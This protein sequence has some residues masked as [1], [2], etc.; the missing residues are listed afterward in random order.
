MKTTGK[1]RLVSGASKLS[2]LAP[3]AHLHSGGARDLTALALGGNTKEDMAQGVD[4]A[5]TGTVAV[6][7]VQSASA[8]ASGRGDEGV[9]EQTYCAEDSPVTGP[10]QERVL[11]RQ[12]DE[13]A[14]AQEPGLRQRRT[15]ARTPLRALTARTGT[16]QRRY[17]TAEVW[18]AAC[19]SMLEEYAV[20][21]LIRVPLAGE[22]QTRTVNVQRGRPSNHPPPPPQRG[23]E[24][25]RDKV[26]KIRIDSQAL[27]ARIARLGWRAYAPK[28]QA[29]EWS[30]NDGGLADRGEGRIEQGFHLLKGS[31]WSLAP[32][33]LPKTE[34]IRGR[35]C[36][37]S[38]TVRALT[39]SRSTVSQSLQ[40]AG[41]TLKGISPAYPH[42]TTNSP[43]AA[44]I[45]TAFASITLAVVHP[46]DPYFVPVSP[47][48]TIQRR[49]LTLLHLPADLYQRIADI[50]TSHHP[51]F[52]EA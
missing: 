24:A 2:A 11:V 28:A 5:V 29:Q 32:V 49:L 9:R 18:P 47:L 42:V 6:T 27:A 15:P 51:L 22:G 23:I 3:R 48:N 16:G 14:Q 17:T 35:L 13:Y 1:D 36:L 39:L 19:P 25:G 34:Q 10:G 31:P 20:A 30:L 7:R 21:G 46:A 41:E 12:S 44:M 38:M 50:L 43:S 52:S 33:S 37:L 4:A 45:L 40:Q 26:R 8:D